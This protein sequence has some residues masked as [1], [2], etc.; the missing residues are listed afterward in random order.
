MYH[1]LAYFFG[2]QS[3]VRYGFPRNLSKK[4]LI[5]APHPDDE[6]IGCAGTIFQ[7][8]KLG[9]EVTIILFTLPV[10][11]DGEDSEREMR[12]QE[13]HDTIFCY[14]NCKNIIFGFSDGDLKSDYE[15][16]RAQLEEVIKELKPGLI[17]TPY[18]MDCHPDHRCVSQMLAEIPMD[19][20]IIIAMYEV[21]VPILHPNFYIDISDVWNEKQSALQSYP[22]QMDQYSILEKV[23]EL[24]Q[25]RAGLSM[26][27]G[28]R[29]IEAFKGTT[30][31]NFM[32]VIKML[33]MEFII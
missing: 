21:W 7:L 28:V 15:Q 20:N 25:L 8:Q 30:V 18:I 26:R 22:S 14:Q 3:K 12:L 16:A 2:V 19:K 4:A 10:K 1:T 6:T 24:N 23:K 33:E 17:F 11:E 5:L 32:T 31:E 27:R 9:Y 13:F 29:Y